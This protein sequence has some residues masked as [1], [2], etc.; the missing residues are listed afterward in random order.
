[1]KEVKN[2]EVKETTKEEKKK[3][4]SARVIVVLVAILVFACLSFISY[5]ANYLNVISVGENYET[6]FNQKSENRTRIFGISA[7]AIF[8]YSL[9]NTAFIKKD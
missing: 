5:R 9:I 6:I 4:I 3:K 2:Q 8:F 1:M 7:I